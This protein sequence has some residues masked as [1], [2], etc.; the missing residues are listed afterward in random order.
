MAELK[1]LDQEAVIA[2]GALNLAPTGDHRLL[3]KAA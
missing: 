3:V 2:C 1:P